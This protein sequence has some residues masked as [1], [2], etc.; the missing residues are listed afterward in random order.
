MAD[1]KKTTHRTFLKTGLATAGA[2]LLY[3]ATPPI[4]ENSKS[5]NPSTNTCWAGHSCC[6]P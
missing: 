5:Q 2:G 4:L 3:A 6:K 1:K